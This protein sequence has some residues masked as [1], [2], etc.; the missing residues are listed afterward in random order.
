MGK[1]LLAGLKDENYPTTVTFNYSLNGENPACRFEN[2]DV[3]IS[4]QM[5]IAL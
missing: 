5:G 2:V 4:L 3:T 1:I